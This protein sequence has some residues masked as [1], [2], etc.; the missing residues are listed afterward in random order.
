MRGLLGR[1]LNARIFK[2]K[3]AVPMGYVVFFIL[4]LLVFIY[5]TLPVDSIKE[6][7]RGELEAAVPYK[8]DIV[9]MDISPLLTVRLRGVE[10]S[11]GKDPGVTIERLDVAPKV[12]SLFAS[13]L[14]LRLRA[15]LFGG[16]ARGELGLDPSGTRIERASL[17]THGIDLGA[18]TRALS[19]LTAKDGFPILEGTLEG[20]ARVEL[21][22]SSAGEFSFSSPNFGIVD[23]H[24]LGRKLSQYKNLKT[25]LLGKI[26][27]DAL[28][29][30]EA[31]LVGQGIDISVSGQMPV[32][33]KLTP[34]G[35]I[36]LAIRLKTDDPKLA[37]LKSILTPKQDGSFGGRITGTWAKPRL[38]KAASFDFRKTRGR[39]P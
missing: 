23:A 8:V 36:D 19:A 37:I 35:A 32:P 12:S 1:I 3:Y 28:R 15:R 13:P 26:E 39:T 21:A 18:A 5:A 34:E 29:I 30:T 22:G 4:S 11:N 24:L 9:S 7:V 20:E 16:D 33:W 27:G 17:R 6:R 2:S 31:H 25:T 10:L 14:S 38:E